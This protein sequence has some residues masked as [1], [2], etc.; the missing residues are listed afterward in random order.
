MGDGHEGG[1]W[2]EDWVF[3]VLD[4]S[5]NSTPQTVFHY[6]ITNL[7]LNLKINK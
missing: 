3:F 2:D 4:G 6:K 1:T 5:L 7:G